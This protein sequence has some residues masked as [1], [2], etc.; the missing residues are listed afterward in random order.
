MTMMM[1]RAID[2]LDLALDLGL[3]VFDLAW[4]ATA[5]ETAQ[6]R[7]KDALAKGFI[8][9]GSGQRMR[10]EGLRNDPPR[11]YMADG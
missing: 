8:S 3:L 11:V 1:M 9:W 2:I 10:T 5:W 4:T 7:A 6:R